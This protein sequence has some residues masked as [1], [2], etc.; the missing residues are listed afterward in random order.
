M[1]VHFPNALGRPPSNAENA[2]SANARSRNLQGKAQDRARR[3][4]P[5]AG[6]VGDSRAKRPG[7]PA[8]PATGD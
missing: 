7:Q 3:D 1:T 5:L 8:D 4:G 6:A 2:M